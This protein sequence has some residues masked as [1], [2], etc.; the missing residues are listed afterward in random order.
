MRLDVDTLYELLP[1]V[2]RIRDLQLAG[3]RTNPLDGPDGPLKSLLAV[4]AD[5]VSALDGNIDRLYDDLF[6]ETCAKWMVPYIGDLIGARRVSA[7]DGTRF[8]E[9]AYVA[10]TMTYRRRKGTASVLEQLAVDVTGWRASAVEYFERLATTQYMNHLRV[11][12]RGVG[13]NVS[14]ANIRNA[15]ALEGPG[16]PFDRTARTADVRRIEARRGRYNIP[17]VGIF[18]YRLWNYAVTDAPAFQV[19]P[20]RYLFDALGKDIQ[21]FNNP[22]T[23]SEIT[24]LAL[25]NNVPQPL[26]RRAFASDKALYYGAGKS[27]SISINGV[28][29]PPDGVDICDLS[30]LGAGWAHTPAVK[31]SVDPEL[32]RI[33]LPSPASP[34]ASVRVTYSYGFSDDIGGGEYERGSSFTL[35]EPLVPVT[36]ANIQ[37]GL[38]QVANTGGVVEVIDNDYFS[39]PLGIQAGTAAG[40]AIELRAA[41]ERRAIL[42][43]AGELTI[44]G[45][46]ESEVTINGLLIAGSI[47]VPFADANGNPNRLRILRLRHCTLAPGPRPSMLGLPAQ[48]SGALLFIDLPEV[49]VEI[50]DSI[51]GGIRAVDSAQI[52]IV[53]SIVD[54]GGAAEVAYA[55]L[56]GSGPGAPLEIRNTTVVGKVH[57]RV[58]T[59]ASNSIFLAE[60]AAADTWTAP[61]AAARL[62]EGC[63]RFSYVPPG[64]RVPKPYQCQPASAADADRV[65]PVFTSLRY[66][67]AGYGQLSQHCAREVRRGADDGA[68]MGA[69]HDLYQPQREENVRTSLD[70][71]L[72]FGLEAGVFLAS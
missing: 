68:E 63:T 59:L 65:R 24:H 12:R 2:Y 6:I 53:N 45:A 10:N 18:L 71:Y 21:L 38:N 30:D 26:A 22:E 19:D 8:T 51:L 1:A 27:V 34:L 44:A 61:V 33:A 66:G 67:D 49:T 64:S 4:L 29:V 47:R 40:N 15:A 37:Q 36:A 16:T 25:P 54:A 28:E 57:T 70:E 5:H 48:A 72:R 17:N 42:V 55:D 7:L 31:V 56:S 46:A 50:D 32:G 35:A 41:A 58:M 52:R 69:F 39:G 3:Q 13:G 14:F 11:P 43:P 62:Q 20:Q 23:E 60:L 9:R